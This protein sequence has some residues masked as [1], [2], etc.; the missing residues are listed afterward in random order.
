MTAK[1][2]VLKF[3]PYDSRIYKSLKSLY[4]YWYPKNADLSVLLSKYAAKMKDRNNIFVIQIG[5]NDGKTNDP[6]FDHVHNYGWNGVFLEPVPSN[7]H[8]LS[9]NYAGNSKVRLY[10]TAI[11]KEPGH[12]IFYTLKDI[13]FPDKPWWYSQ[14][15]SFRREVLLKHKEYLPHIE[16]LIE[17]V[18]VQ[19]KTIKELYQESGRD[20]VNLIHID[21]EGYDYEILKTID[22]TFDQPDLILFEHH[23]L[24]FD[25]YKKSISIL[26][27]NK[28][29]CYK[30]GS[31]TL[32][33]KAD[34]AL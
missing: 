18:D 23:H 21:T 6:I 2:L 1:E 20:H 3:F 33:I 29:T 27:A 8:K 14:V 7:F 30:D 17:E 12:L 16:S 5:S 32:A 19:V 11:G 4:L 10:N 28:Y 31:D 13:D 25:D 34:I 22:F 26:K 15:G 9:A 24:S